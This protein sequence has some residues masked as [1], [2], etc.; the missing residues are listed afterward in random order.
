MKNTLPRTLTMKKVLAP[1][2]FTLSVAAASASTHQATSLASASFETMKV[3]TDALIRLQVVEPGDSAYGALVCPGCG[4]THSRA[5]EA[6]YPLAVAFQRTLDEK[7]RKAARILAEW[8]FRQQQPGGEW[9]ETPW[10]WTGTTADQLLMLAEAYPIIAPGLP[11]A[12]E[13]R[14]KE[15]MRKAA[16]YLVKVMDPAFASINYCPTTAAALMVTDA[17]IP[18]PVY[19]QK[20]RRLAHQVI[21]KMDEAGFIQGEAARAHGVKYGVDLG[22]EMDMSL[23]GLGL[24]ARLAGDTTVDRAVRRSLAKNLP[25]VYPN[26]A[27]DGSWGSRCYKWTTYGS[28]TAD[29]CQILFG[30]YGDEDPR[31][32]TAA[33]RNLEYLRGMISGGMLGNGPGH[34][35]LFPEKTCIYPTF[36]RAKNL[37]LTVRYCVERSPQ[38][39][40]LPPIPS[41]RPGWLRVYPTVNVAVARSATFMLTVSAYSYRDPSRTNGGQYNQHPTG[42]SVCN[43]W[44]A[45]AGFL[46]TSSQTRYVRG[47]SI[48]M[49]PVADS[50]ICLTPRVE[51]RDSLGYFTNLYEF[52]GRMSA[53]ASA[54]SVAIITTS[55]ELKDEH[56][57]PGGVGFSISNVLFD[58]AVEKT[59]TLSFHDRR[60]TVRVVE[61]VVTADGT[62]IQFAGSR[63]LF[64]NTRDRTFIVDLLDGD[65]EFSTDREFPKY[66]FPFPAMQATPIVILVPPPSSGTSR[67]IRYRIAQGGRFI[68]EIPRDTYFTMSTAL[69][70]AKRTHPAAKIPSAAVRSG[71]VTEK[72]LVYVR[73]GTRRM[74]LDLCRPASVGATR[75]AVLILHGGG[76]RSGDRSM[77]IPMA[78]RFARNGYVAAVVE[79]RLSPRPGIRPL[80]TIAGMPSAGCAR[81][82]VGT[83]S[84]RTGSP[85][86]VD[87]RADISQHCW[88]RPEKWT[89]V[90]GAVSGRSSTSMDR[91]I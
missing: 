65:G 22:Y 26:G 56:W 43:L 78:Q 59:I 47:E 70:R 24:Y 17:I 91:W 68:H 8:L 79:Y 64:I 15:S 58:D 61:P 73:R 45:G 11:A 2:L 19:V 67:T 42:G 50:A 71:I 38:L 18:D 77:E 87:P 88:R 5:A 85:C 28:K 52:E 12:E 3:L 29:G 32:I 63:R 74:H 49:P 89:A 72:N 9:L 37:A 41:D 35:S 51:Y 81:M 90:P 25:F 57:L 1:V 21:A 40:P 34:W 20:A 33:L 39:K 36:A 13:A 62:S 31:Y 80:S 83:R 14:W 7:Y 48:H 69:E 6:V 10:T 27:V 16:D 86:W 55:G 23:W 30:L 60:P 66:K 53:R 46:T 44:A 4:V 82:P 54:E 75:P 84:T 76:W